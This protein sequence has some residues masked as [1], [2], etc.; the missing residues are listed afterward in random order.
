MQSET[1]GDNTGLPVLTGTRVRLRNSLV[2]TAIL[3]T[4]D[5]ELC[6][7][8]PHTEPVAPVGTQPRLSLEGF[9]DLT[10]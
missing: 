2:A 6:P 5:G 4:T 7:S 1:T 9:K 8:G 10:N 3:I